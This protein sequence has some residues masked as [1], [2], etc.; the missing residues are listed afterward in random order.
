MAPK[1]MKR[2][3]G[4]SAGA[5]AKK[6]ATGKCTAICSALTAAQGPLPEAVLSMISKMLPDALLTY[7]EERHEFQATAVSM[8]GQALA[9]IEAEL[10][11]AIVPLEAKVAGAEQEEAARK[12]AQSS[13]QAD[14]DAK[15]AD[16]AAKKEAFDTSKAVLATAIA[17]VGDA[18]KAQKEGDSEAE[19]TVK[20]KDQMAALMATFEALKTA[21]VSARDLKAALKSLD[22]FASE[23][24]FDKEVVKSAHKTLSTP[25]DA[26]GTFDGMI[27]AELDKVLGGAAASIEATIANSMPEKEARA[28]AVEAAIAARTAANDQNLGNSIALTDAQKALA[29]AEAALKAAAAHVK[30][31]SSEAAA[32]VKECKAAKDKLEAFQGKAMA[33]FAELQAYAP[34]PPPPAPVVEEPAPA[35]E[36]APAEP[37]PE[38]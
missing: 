26:R 5:A 38:A 20:L 36:A 25:A 13:A 24:S 12:A 29:E 31:F 34:P 3:A 6:Q 28:A 9:S 4:S 30:G 8:A 19:K 35:A 14:L 23:F 17:A 33:A 32:A 18:E 27:I 21:P 16:V 1:G 10:Q 37:A 22:T 11:A 7:A 15:K 2:P